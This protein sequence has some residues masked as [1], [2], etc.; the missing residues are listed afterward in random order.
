MQVNISVQMVCNMYNLYTHFTTL[1]MFSTVF[2]L[3]EP[4][5][6]YTSSQFV[7]WRVMHSACN[8]VSDLY[9]VIFLNFQYCKL[10]VLKTVKSLG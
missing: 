8:W 10:L 2:P 1:H 4:R 5:T 7:A 9:S 6:D 3:S